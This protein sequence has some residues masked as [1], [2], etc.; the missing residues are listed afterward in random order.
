MG[1]QLSQASG[2]SV[3]RGGASSTQ[4]SRPKPWGTFLRVRDSAGLQEG[5]V[6][7][8]S[9]TLCPLPHSFPAQRRTEQPQESQVPCPR[10]DIS[11]T[12]SDSERRGPDVSRHNFIAL[13]IGVNFL[14]R[15]AKVK[16]KEIALEGCMD[17]L[18]DGHQNKEDR[19]LSP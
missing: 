17:L 5:K 16:R 2:T 1:D 18:G 11:S 19:I 14:M 15:V 13:R 6:P 12:H 9:H 4:F 8:L 3:S 7:G 10:T